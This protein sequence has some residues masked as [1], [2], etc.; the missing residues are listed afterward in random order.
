M[1]DMQSTLRHNVDPFQQTQLDDIYQHPRPYKYFSFEQEVVSVGEF[2]NIC[3]PKS[4]ADLNPIFRFVTISIPII[5][6][7]ALV[8]WRVVRL[9][10]L[11]TMQ[12]FKLRVSRSASTT[13]AVALSRLACAV[14]DILACWR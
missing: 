7:W 10:A 3:T 9:Y 4:I 13:S 12:T 11:H 6:K 8:M 5:L 2:E 1:K 14:G